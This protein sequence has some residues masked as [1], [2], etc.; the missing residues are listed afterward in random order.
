[1]D[2]NLQSLENIDFSHS[3]RAIFNILKATLQYPANPQAKGAKLAND[4]TFFFKSPEEDDCIENILWEVWAVIIDIACCIPSGH[5][6]QESLVQSLNSLRQRDGFIRG[7]VSY[8]NY[9]SK[10][11]HQSFTDDI[12]INS[13]YGRIFQIYPSP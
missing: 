9:Y 12:S 11:N 10:Y 2:V 5:L 3:E 13:L 6:W 4:I 8:T 1:M 7:K